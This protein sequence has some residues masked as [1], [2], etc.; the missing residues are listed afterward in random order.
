MANKEASY[1]K[2]ILT[3]TALAALGVA[4][5]L[6]IL[7]SDFSESLVQTKVSQGK[8]FPEIPLTEVEASTKRLLE[9]ADWHPPIVGNKPVPLN[10]SVIMVQKGDT[11]HDL[12]LEKEPLRPPMTNQYLREN[13][14]DFL[15]PNVAELDPDDD[16]FSNLEEFE[17]K[18][19]PKDAQS[20]PPLTNKLVFKT[21]FQDN[22]IVA[23]LTSESPIQVKR[24]EPPGP[25]LFIDT[26]KL[27]ATPQDFG[28]ERGAPARFRALGFE[29]KQPIGANGLPKDQSE[30]TILDLATNEKFVL[31]LGEPKNLAAYQAVLEFNYR[32]RREYKPQ[33]GQTF[34]IE[35]V[36]ATFMLVDVTETSATIA[37]VVDGKPGKALVLEQK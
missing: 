23:L 29:K 8:A 27:P 24:K 14:L 4:G 17:G 35:G 3:L 6:Y 36:G 19:N 1:D 7:K 21:R 9:V 13:G 37:E 22:Y 30:L 31:A 34:R 26:T 25:G 10:K 20:H 28:F 15:A 33:K 2:V 32:K 18:T 12:F 11:L 5:Y 16:G